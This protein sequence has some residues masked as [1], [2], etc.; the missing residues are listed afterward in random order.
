MRPRIKICGITTPEDALVAVEAGADYLG[1][2]FFSGSPRRIDVDGAR[3]IRQAVGPQ[4]PLVGVF[5]NHESAEVEDLAEELA[6]DL[7]QF[8]GDE[9]ADYCRGWRQRVIKAVRV[10]D[11]AA[12]AQVAAYPV[13][14]LL[15]DAYVEGHFGGTG[16]R[17][18]AQWLED[19]ARERLI[20]AGGL[21]P[22]DVAEA[23][24]Q[25]RPVMVDVASGVERLPGQKDPERVKQ[26]VANAQNA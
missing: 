23:V 26:F 2:N 7:L 13:D 1:L 17:V 10:R 5:V 9:T 3:R 22:E 11:R 21:T 15:A 16:R 19:V 25:V 20:L 24:R 18:S 14:F 6:L 8:H 12:V 4:V